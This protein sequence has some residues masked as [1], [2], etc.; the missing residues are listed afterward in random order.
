MRIDILNQDWLDQNAE[1]LA[2]G[3]CIPILVDDGSEFIKVLSRDGKTKLDIIPRYTD[4]ERIGKT[5]EF[6]LKRDHSDFSLG[7]RC[8]GDCPT[9]ELLDAESLHG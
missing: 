4:S 3:R 8:D 2:S 7:F 9:C 6:W 1:T 5:L